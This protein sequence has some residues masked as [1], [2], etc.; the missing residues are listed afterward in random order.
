MPTY[1]EIVFLLY[2]STRAIWRNFNQIFV[3]LNLLEYILHLKIYWWSLWS[4]EKLTGLV[5]TAEH[6]KANIGFF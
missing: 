3:I 6:Q 1:Q 5:I 2:F 4:T